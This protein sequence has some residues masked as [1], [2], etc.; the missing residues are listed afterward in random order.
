MLH[1]LLTTNDSFVHLIRILNEIRLIIVEDH[2]RDGGSSLSGLLLQL[3]S[4]SWIVDDRNFSGFIHSELAIIYESLNLQSHV[5]S[6]AEVL[7]QFIISSFKLLD[8]SKPSCKFSFGVGLD[9]LLF[10]DLLLG[11]SPLGR[12]LHEMAG[13]TFGHYVRHKHEKLE[14]EDSGI[15]DKAIIKRYLPLTDWLALKIY[16][17]SGS[18][19]IIMSCS[20]LILSFRFCIYALT[21]K[22][23][24]L[25]TMV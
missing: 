24:G 12:H 4:T 8:L 25:P 1:D 14:I 9:L 6:F 15:L 23:K 20:A 10:L 19:S 17:I 21:H 18:M 16:S 11:P 2:S 22:A 3:R 7:L 5:L 13:V